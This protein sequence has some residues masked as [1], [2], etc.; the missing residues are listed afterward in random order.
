MRKVG[1]LGREE[2]F[3]GT[4]QEQQLM[5]LLFFEN[6]GVAGTLRDLPGHEARSHKLGTAFWVFGLGF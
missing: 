6:S 5:V 4:E 3:L 2:I 1:W